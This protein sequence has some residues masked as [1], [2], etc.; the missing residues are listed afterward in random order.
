MIMEVALSLLT[1]LLVAYLATA[2]FYYLFQERFIFVRYQLTPLSRFKFRFPY[3]ERYL[4]ADDGVRLHAL[5]FKAEKPRGVVLYFHGNTGNLRRWGKLAPR[6]TALG[7]DVLMPD[8]RG[9][10]K[11]GGGLSAKALQGDA[12]AWYD[13]LKAHWKEENIVLYGRSLGS[14]MAVPVAA[15]RSPRLLVLETPF[16]NLLD[17]ARN[18]LR[19]LPY[20]LVLRYPFRNDMAIRR[21][22]CPVY[23][24]HGK[25]DDV[26]PYTSALKLYS[27]VPTTV[28]REMHTFAKGRHSDLAR[29]VRFNREIRRILA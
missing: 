19:I 3:E 21:V 6:F 28:H 14:G 9:Y 1:L 23:I 18:F 27:L 4:D 29:F 7:Y 12:L 11:S 15:G 5:Y 20:K 16:A 26:V 24:F 13:S 17:V 25:R 10:G 22:R 2:L 8:Y